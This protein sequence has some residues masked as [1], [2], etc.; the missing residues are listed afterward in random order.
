VIP[1]LEEVLGAYLHHQ[2]RKGLRPASERGVA[3]ALDAARGLAAE[4]RDEPAA[5]L[6]AFATYRRA[7]H[8]GWR[9]MAAALTISQAHEAGYFIETTQADMDALLSAVMYGTA[10]YE[11][12][13]AWVAARLRP[14]YQS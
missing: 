14:L 13:R 2:R 4:E 10:D 8:G 3:A 12:V 11:D 1:L 7:F 9:F 6:F 5:M